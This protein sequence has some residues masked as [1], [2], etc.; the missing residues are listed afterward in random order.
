M[1]SRLALAA[2]L[3]CAA[4]AVAGT[5][6]DA[7]DPMIGTGGGGHTYPGATAPFGMVQLSPDTDTGCVI[8]SCYAHAAGYQYGDPT[9]QG[10]SHTHFS[11]AGHSDLGDFLVMPVSGDAVPLEPGDPQKPG[12]G[13]RSRFD[14][15]SE[16]AHPGYYAVTLTDA[17]VRAELTAV[18]RVGA[19]RYTFAAGKAAHLV[20]DLR[21][22]L[23]N[24]PGKTLW[25]SIRLRPDGTVTGCRQTRGWAPDRI[26]CFAM[27]FSAPLTDHAFADTETNIA[28]KGFRAPA[29]A[30]MRSPRRRGARWSRA[31]ISA[32]LRTRSR[33]RS[34]S[35][36][37]TR[38]ARSPISM[39]SPAI[40][41]RSASRPGPRGKPRWARSICKRRRR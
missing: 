14:H 26:L 28:Y 7:V 18:T 39:P 17:H 27:R 31:S 40:S 29:A 25:S 9:I 5:T 22:S 41:T 1:I 15:R 30:A 24:Y 35:P 21:T 8:R 32:T 19:H 2:A 36:R 4:P 13:Y 12:S 20:L 33:S 16:V 10:F 3:L 38:R 37:S 11:G 6:Y 23:Y 34:R